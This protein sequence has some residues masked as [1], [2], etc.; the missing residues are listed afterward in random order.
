MMTL[1]PAIRIFLQEA[2]ARSALVAMELDSFFKLSTACDLLKDALE[3]KNRDRMDGIAD[4][5]DVAVSAY[6]LAFKA[7]YGLDNMRFKHHQMMHLASQLRR[8]KQLLACWVLERKH[9]SSK[10]GFAHYKQSA[11]MPRGAL[12]R[13]VNKQVPIAAF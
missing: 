3:C 6:L 10:Q 7:A 11:L 5:L 12:A 1:Y 9:I 2:L 4:Q 13:I 8:D